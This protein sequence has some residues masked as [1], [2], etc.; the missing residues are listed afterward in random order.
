MWNGQEA[1]HRQDACTTSFTSLMETLY[2]P[3]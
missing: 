3:V 2:L 1:R